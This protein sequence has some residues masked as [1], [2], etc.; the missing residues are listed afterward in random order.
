MHSS[1]SAS[2]CTE[3]DL[4]LFYLPNIPQDYC[5]VTTCNDGVNVIEMVTNQVNICSRAFLKMYFTNTQKQKLF[6]AHLYH[7]AFEGYGPCSIRSHTP[8]VLRVG[9][10]NLPI[11]SLTFLVLSYIYIYSI[12]QKPLCRATYKSTFKSMNPESARISG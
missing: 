1:L 3:H 12:L 6:Y 9:S 5:S 8:T 7:S 11:S 4:L 2:V 10:H